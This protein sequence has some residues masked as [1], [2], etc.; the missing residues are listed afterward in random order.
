MKS[1]FTK[2]ANLLFQV[3]GV[4]SNIPL[5][6][7]PNSQYIIQIWIKWNIN[8]LLKYLTDIQR[9]KYNIKPIV[10]CFQET[11][12]KPYKK[13][14]I[15]GYEGYFKNHH[16]AACASG[17]VAKYVTNLI[18]SKVISIQSNLE[19]ITVLIQLKNPLY[20]CNI[21]VP[22]S[23]NLS[24]QDLNQIIQQLPK[25]FILLGDFNSRNQM[26]GSNHTDLRG[27]TME[28]FLDNDQLNTG[29]Y[30]RHDSTNKFFSD[31]SYQYDKIRL[32]NIQ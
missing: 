26:W 19:V 16:N 18:K 11:N 12:L 32:I 24:L 14:P 29:K 15:H 4:H 22:D 31:I 27:K 5:K 2:F 1:R 6:Q 21:Y 8:G 20:I 30:I 9:A 23:T 3:Q 28:T 7:K 10:F 13:F 25:P 17:S